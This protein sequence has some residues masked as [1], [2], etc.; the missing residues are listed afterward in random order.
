MMQLNL[1]RKL[2]THPRLIEDDESEAAQ[3]LKVVD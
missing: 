1:L 2:T 3:K